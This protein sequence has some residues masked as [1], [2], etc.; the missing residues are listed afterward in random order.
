MTGLALAVAPLRYL[1]YP[2]SALAAID[3][4]SCGGGLSTDGYTAFCC[5]IN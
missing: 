4:G 3:P 1:L 2:I 5:E